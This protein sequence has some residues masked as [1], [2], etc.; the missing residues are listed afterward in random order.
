MLNPPMALFEEEDRQFYHQQVNHQAKKDDKN[1]DKENVGNC[2]TKSDSRSSNAP[3]AT[4]S[5]PSV[6]VATSQDQPEFVYNAVVH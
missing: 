5:R 4:A 6:V 1:S 2:P 3:T